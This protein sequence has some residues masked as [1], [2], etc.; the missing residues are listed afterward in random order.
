MTG[1]ITH[2]KQMINS[3]SLHINCDSFPVS[4]APIVALNP[5]KFNH[6]KVVDDK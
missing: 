1:A 3:R 5:T 2:N 6:P 4:V